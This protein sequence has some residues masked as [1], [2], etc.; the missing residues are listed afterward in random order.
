MK[1]FKE[2][3]YDIVRLYV[4]QLGIMI[5]SMLLNISVGVLKNESLA[6]TLSVIVSVFSIGFYLTLIYYVIWEIGAKDKIRVD[7]GRAEPCKS[8]GLVMS[9]FANVPN[10]VLG[11]LTIISLSI[12]MVGG[13]EVVYSVFLIVNLLMRWH[14]SM[15]LGVIG[16]IAPL[17]ES[18]GT[19][20][21]YTA[22][23][24]QAILFT[25]LPLISVLVT[26]LGYTL[27]FKEKKLFSFLT[28]KK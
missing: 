21:N 11:L 2:N 28:N 8:K 6:S 24:V 14:A 1:I 22:Y 3:S 26:H 10:L 15:F 19:D 27:G 9:L 5:F 13:N 7:G 25:V 4:N 18:V 23:L 16:V 12:F 20:I 17:G